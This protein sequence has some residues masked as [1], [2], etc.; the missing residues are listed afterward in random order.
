[1]L[2]CEKC[3]G[4]RAEPSI[5][6]LFIFISV[7]SSILFFTKAS[8]LELARVVVYKSSLVFSWVNKRPRPL[9]GM[10]IKEINGCG[11][12]GGGAPSPPY[13]KD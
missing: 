4:L 10:K 8:S 6:F 5:S 9:S 12:G 3:T 13:N 1:M 11:G 7:R 2:R